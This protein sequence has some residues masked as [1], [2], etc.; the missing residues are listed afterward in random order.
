MKNTQIKKLKLTRSVRTAMG[1]ELDRRGSIP[2]RGN[3]CLLHSV[4]TGYGAHPASYPMGTGGGGGGEA[5][6]SPPSSTDVENSGAT[7]LLSHTSSWRGA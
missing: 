4:Q 3:I 2:C 1:Y 5:D 7:P 6:H